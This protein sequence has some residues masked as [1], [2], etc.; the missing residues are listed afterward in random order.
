MRA[1]ILRR[2]AQGVHQI[3]QPLEVLLGCR[4]AA[5]IH[6]LGTTGNPQRAESLRNQAIGLRGTGSQRQMPC[7]ALEGAREQLSP[8]HAASP[9][10]QAVEARHKQAVG[11]VG[12]L[13]PQMT[14]HRHGP[15]DGIAD[16]GPRVEGILARRL[17][18]LEAVR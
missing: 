11:V 5:S 3:A 16:D 8:A 14:H 7:Q 12:S 4:V 6:R 18:A 9:R 1:R 17:D 2:V 10:T 15:P 13:A